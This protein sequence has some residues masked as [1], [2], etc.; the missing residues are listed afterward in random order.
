MHIK[1][2]FIEYNKSLFLM[3]FRNCVRLELSSLKINGYAFLFSVIGL[4]CFSRRKRKCLIF[5]KFMLKY[6]PPSNLLHILRN[7]NAKIFLFEST[8]SMLCRALH[9]WTRDPSFDLECHVFV[10]SPELGSERD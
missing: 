2:C 6:F 5:F 7:I 9:S 8:N 1:Y 4:L 10:I 3:Y